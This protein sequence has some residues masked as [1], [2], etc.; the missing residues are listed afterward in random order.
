MEGIKKK[1]RKFG[2]NTTQFVEGTCGKRPVPSRVRHLNGIPKKEGMTAGTFKNC[3]GAVGYNKVGV[4]E[5]WRLFF[6]F[7]ICP[8][9]ASKDEEFLF[10]FLN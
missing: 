10:C 7:I 1:K 2:T 4:K 5:F 9:P 8:P 6:W 3:V